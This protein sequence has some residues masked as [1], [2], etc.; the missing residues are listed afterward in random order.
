MLGSKVPFYFMNMFTSVIMNRP[1]NCFPA[2]LNDKSQLLVFSSMDPRP[3]SAGWKKQSRLDCSLKLDGV[4]LRLAA[5][6]PE[7]PL[8]L[9]ILAGSNRGL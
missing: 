1:P 8:P 3:R 7:P 4:C 2:K 6:L 5:F 9:L